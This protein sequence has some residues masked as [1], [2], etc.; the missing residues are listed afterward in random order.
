MTTLRLCS[1]KKIQKTMTTTRRRPTRVRGGPRRHE[2]V[3]VVSLHAAPRA[4]TPRASRLPRG[5]PPA[6]TLITADMDTTPQETF[7]RL[8]ESA[9][10]RDSDANMPAVGERAGRGGMVGRGRGAALLFLLLWRLSRSHESKSAPEHP[11][12]PPPAA[13]LITA[14]MDTTPQ[15]TFLRLLESA[16]A[17]RVGTSLLALS[18]CMPL[19]EHQR[20]ERLASTTPAV[21]VARRCIGRGRCLDAD[22]TRAP[23]WTAASCDAHHGRY[24]YDSARDFSPPL[25]T[26]AAL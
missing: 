25:V 18:R 23:A 4:S 13:T 20:R 2:L 10:A 19:R 24:G 8:L 5:P 11:R 1:R 22:R 12:G 17:D 26:L 3:G 6:A 7:L 9:Q 16:Q 21:V 14:D 15:E